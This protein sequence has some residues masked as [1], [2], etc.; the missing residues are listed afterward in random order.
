MAT[1]KSIAPTPPKASNAV[2]ARDFLDLAFT[3]ENGST[4]PVFT[5]F[6]GPVTVKVSGKATPTLEPDLE[7]LLKRL[8]DEA[9]IPISRITGP[10]TASITIVPVPS[11]Q[12]RSVAPTAACFVRANVSSWDEYRARR[13]DP[14]TFW[15]G[16]R[17]RDRMAI[18]VP[19]DVSPQETRDCLH[20][21][22]AQ[23]LGP[24]NDLYRLS[25]SIFNDDNFHTVLTGYDMLILRTHYDKA[26]QNGMTRA[27][28]AARLPAILN[29]L[30]PRGRSSA[31]APPHPASRDWKAAINTATN[32]RHS[33]TRRKASAEKA[34]ALAT[35]GNQTDANIAYSYYI[36]GRLSLA[37]DPRQA[38][39][40]FLMAG[41]IY[42]SQPDTRIQ[43]AHV[44]LQVAAFQ[45]AAGQS[46][47]AI[48][49]IDQNLAVVRRSE[50]AALLSLML[51]VK[52]EGFENLGQK[53]KAESA[54]KEAL[55]WARYGYGNEAVIRERVS[56]IL[57]ISPRMRES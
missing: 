46:D 26:L 34:V 9:N 15:T 7:R 21:E 55:A 57:S 30:N 13:N 19:T 53:A 29:R 8:R 24:V 18:F 16:L 6:N 25:D 28:V 48:A 22:V 51:L 40:A 35:L 42:E 14:A 56:E 4:L 41:R 17:Q 49:L 1:F 50:H 37:S 27:E 11:A 52:A 54:R 47:I 44:A 2:I 32:P 45:L 39:D 31:I 38:L 12:I 10:Q 23:A 36:L 3:L 20:E 43:E 33:N 5:R